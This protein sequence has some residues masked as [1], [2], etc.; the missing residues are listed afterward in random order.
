MT[1]FTVLIDMDDT[2]E[3]LTQEWVSYLNEKYNLDKKWEDLKYWDMSK[4]FPTLNADQIFE[5]LFE[6]QFWSRVTPLPGAVEN[7]KK[8]IDDGHSVFIVTTSCLESLKH[9]TPL[10]LFKYFPY[11]TWKNIIIA[12]DKGMIEGDVIIDD[13]PDNLHGRRKLKCLMD[14][15][16]NRSYNT[17]PFTIR[18]DS[19]DEIYK[20]I[21]IYSGNLGRS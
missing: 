21:C 15:P 10:V 9:K 4:N 20:K 8:I 18:V 1:K 7:I 13:N 5:P 12:A 2:I 14:A 17:D 19:W 3:N 11:L 16:H 6:A